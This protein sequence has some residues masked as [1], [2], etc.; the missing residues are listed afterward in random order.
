MTKWVSLPIELFHARSEPYLATVD[1]VA[2]VRRAAASQGGHVA[3]VEIG[4]SESTGDVIDAL[5]QVL[6]CPDWSGSSWD[7]I[8]DAFEELHQAWEFPLILVV[9]GLDR[10]LDRRRQLALQVVVRFFELESDFST[11]QEQMTP[12]YVADAWT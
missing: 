12:V 8:H 1:H 10:L 4:E 2:A 6:P 5:R 3:E 11:V 7:S 9:A